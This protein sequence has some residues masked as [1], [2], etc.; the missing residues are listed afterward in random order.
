LRAVRA[1]A[2]AADDIDT[3]VDAAQHGMSVPPE[4]A[5]TSIREE[6]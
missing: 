5:S 6:S 3:W 4:F 2:G 1:A